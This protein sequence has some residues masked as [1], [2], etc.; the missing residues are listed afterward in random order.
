M[1]DLADLRKGHAGDL[2]IEID[3]IEVRH[4]GDE[5][6]DRLNVVVQMIGGARYDKL[7]GDELE[8]FFRFDIPGIEDGS[9]E[10]LQHSA[11]HIVTGDLDL[12]H[13]AMVIEMLDG[14]G[15]DLFHQCQ[16]PGGEIVDQGSRNRA[17]QEF[18]FLLHED[19][20]DPEDQQVDEF[21]PEELHLLV[22]VIYIIEYLFHP[23]AGV[24]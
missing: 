12:H 18:G 9:K 1:P 24:I 15:V 23:V 10:F 6:D 4:S 20:A 11:N 22:I 16:L 14:E 19:I 13:G 17:G 3:C 7:P 21:C 8:Q 2:S 5:V